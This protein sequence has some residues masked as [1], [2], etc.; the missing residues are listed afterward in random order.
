MKLRWPWSQKPLPAIVP[1]LPPVVV[2][3]PV[4]APPAPVTFALAPPQPTPQR[5]CATLK[6]GKVE[7]HSLCGRGAPGKP[8]PGRVVISSGHWID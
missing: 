7:Y 6:V 4:V 8:T 5:F 2:E 3:P 1:D